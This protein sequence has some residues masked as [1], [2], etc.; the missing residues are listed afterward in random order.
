MKASSSR[1]CSPS[2]PRTDLATEG[3]WS[4]DVIETGYSQRGYA[5]VNR[6]F[7]SSSVHWAHWR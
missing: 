3:R 7:G 5:S 4:R 2:L 1:E 6:I